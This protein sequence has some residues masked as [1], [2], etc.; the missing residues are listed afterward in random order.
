MWE[1]TGLQNFATNHEA[2]TYTVRTPLG[3]PS[4]GNQPPQERFHQGQ[5]LVEKRIEG[6]KTP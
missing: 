2:S 6:T 5:Q 1:A 3:K 4:L